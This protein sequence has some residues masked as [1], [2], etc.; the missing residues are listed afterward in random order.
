MSVISVSEARLRGIALP[1]DDDAAQSIIDEQES[2][3]S[4]RIGAL[5]GSRTE[6][7]TV[8]WSFDGT[9]HLSRY[10]DT[11]TV[12]DGAVSLTLDVGYRL[13]RRSIVTRLV[14]GY[15]VCWFGPTVGVTYTPDEDDV[16]RVLFDLVG[17]SA[18]PAGPYESEQIGAYSYR[19]SAQG[20]LSVPSQRAALASSLVP[21][22]AGALSLRVHR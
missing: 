18:A 16:R 7:F 8:G 14:G 21:P 1:S 2:W 12:T 15:D 22:G 6:T 5:T 9:V 19:R 11:A 3:L 13:D 17:L 4:A 10:T 20:S